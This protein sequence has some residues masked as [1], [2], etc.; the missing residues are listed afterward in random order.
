MFDIAFSELV[1]I[2]LVALIVVGPKQLPQLARTIGV[3][4]GR[5]HRQ[6]SK[7]K[8]DIHRELQVQE[9]QKLDQDM[10][11]EMKAMQAEMHKQ[12]QEFGAEAWPGS[13]G[14]TDNASSLPVGPSRP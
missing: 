8:A 13:L 12:V 5:A 11:D 14:K 4:L 10:H 9:L 7:L 1:L 2:L 6:F 3:L